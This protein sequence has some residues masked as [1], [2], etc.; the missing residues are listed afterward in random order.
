MTFY[1]RLLRLMR[2]EKEEKDEKEPQPEVKERKAPEAKE[3]MHNEREMNDVLV[4]E[5][6][7]EMDEGEMD[8][9][10]E[11]ETDENEEK[12]FLPFPYSTLSRAPIVLFKD[13]VWKRAL[14]KSS[15]KLI[16]LNE[17]KKLASTCQGFYGLIKEY[18]T[19]LP[20]LLLIVR[21]GYLSSNGS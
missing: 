6:D 11:N 3:R 4:E 13:D 20:Y 2:E 21:T 18:V 7:G 10:E 14:S 19:L 1:L 9:E 5:R 17:L 15:K 16:G 8:E 12:S